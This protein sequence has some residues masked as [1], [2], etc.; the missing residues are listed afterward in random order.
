[1]TQTENA[2]VTMYRI[3]DAQN[4]NVGH[5]ETKEDAISMAEEHERLD[6]NGRGPY[7]VRRVPK[8]DVHL[9][10]PDVYPVVYPNDD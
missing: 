3:E 10:G 2:E 9:N 4:N 7:H 8:K 6:F 1:M 5:A